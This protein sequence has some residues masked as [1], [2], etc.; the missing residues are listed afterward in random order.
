MFDPVQPYWTVTQKKIGSAS[1][2]VL[3][4]LCLTHLVQDF[5]NPNG[6]EPNQTKKPKYFLIRLI[7]YTNNFKI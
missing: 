7:K 1:G 3:K 5:I 4:I 6:S 2:P